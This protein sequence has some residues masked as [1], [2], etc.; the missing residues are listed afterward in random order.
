MN[1]QNP[2]Q[3]DAQDMAELAG[4][5]DAAL[6][7]LID[8]HGQKLFHYFVRLLHNETDAAELAQETFVRIY[9]SRQKFDPRLK[10]TTWLYTIASNLVRDRF[11]W[12]SRH[13]Q[14]SLHSQN[15][16]EAAC[17][18]HTVP[19]SA[20][21]PDDQI[22]TKERTAIIR[23]AIGALP[24]ELRQ[25]LILAVYQELPQSEIAT[26]LG[27]SA[28]AVEMRIYRARQQLRARLAHL[29]QEA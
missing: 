8:R 1:P 20:P 26:V 19:A 5:R 15:E 23:R 16:Q 17:L 11:R 12:R 22:Q 28:K 27:C 9:Q 6:S 2:V 29:L 4:G 21:G 13:P 14:I 7:S 18:M 3:Q 24:E 10:F 25:P